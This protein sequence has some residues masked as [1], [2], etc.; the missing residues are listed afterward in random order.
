MATELRQAKQAKPPS[1]LT[2]TFQGVP[3]VEPLDGGYIQQTT[4]VRAVPYEERYRE[5]T[6]RLE[7]P[8]EYLQRGVEEQKAASKPKRRS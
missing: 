8:A 2:E 4:T 3:A 1:T 5:S 7:T 6:A